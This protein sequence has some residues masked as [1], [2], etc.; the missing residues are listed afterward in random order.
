MLTVPCDTPRF[1]LDLAERMAQAINREGADIAMAAA[2]ETNAQ[3]Q[4]EV[5][6]Q[7]VFCLLR[8]SLLESL[9]TF[10]QEGGRK[11]DRWTSQHPTVL[12]PFDLP[13]DDRRAFFNANTGGNQVAKF[14]D[15]ATAEKRV[16]ALIAEMAAE[17]AGDQAAAKAACQRGDEVVPADDAPDYSSA[18]VAARVAEAADAPR[19]F[20]AERQRLRAEA[21]R[22]EAL[23]ALAPRVRALRP[24]G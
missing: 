20:A 22:T 19:R 18:A 23:A 10:T 16:L 15:R 7:P 24:A 6:T 12:V 2:L 13:G 5:R 1:P 3:G 4:T 17:E 21:E 8:V 11:I 14:R 9:V